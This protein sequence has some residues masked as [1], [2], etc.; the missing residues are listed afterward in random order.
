MVARIERSISPYEVEIPRAD[1]MRWNAVRKGLRQLADA[2]TAKG[3][4]DDEV[5]FSMRTLQSLQD[6]ET[7]STAAMDVDAELVVVGEGR[8]DGGKTTS[9]TQVRPS[10]RPAS[11]IE[12]TPAVDE[13]EDEDDDQ[14]EGEGEDENEDDEDEDGRDEDDEKDEEDDGEEGEEDA[15]EE[16]DGE[17]KEDGRD[18]DGGVSE[19]ESEGEAKKKKKVPK[20]KAKAGAGAK[21]AKEPREKVNKAYR[22]FTEG[23]HTLW[24]TMVR[25]Y[26]FFLSRLL[27]G[28]VV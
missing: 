8:R 19:D 13:D 2:N 15:D 20:A 9:T 22:P 24:D 5:S 18:E 26:C 6:E 1:Q 23:K 3:V 28:C 25:F 14:Y 27:T 17:E 4:A 11:K 16:S 7:A 12:K 10:I 21:M